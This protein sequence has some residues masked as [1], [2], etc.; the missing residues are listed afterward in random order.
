MSDFLEDVTKIA[1]PS[2]TQNLDYIPTQVIAEYFRYGLSGD[3][4]PVQGILWRSSKDPTVTSCII[5]A[6][7]DLMTD[8]HSRVGAAIGDADPLMVLI[9]GS[10]QTF[11]AP[12]LSHVPP[13]S[14]L[15]AG[16]AA[17]ADLA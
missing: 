9:S 1:D 13:H 17:Y 5:F 4:G 3:A 6:A 11:P 12:L 15:V 8:H 10:V 2:D 14:E 7:Q 16:E